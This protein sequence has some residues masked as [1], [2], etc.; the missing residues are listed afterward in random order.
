MRRAII[1]AASLALVV[2]VADA[3]NAKTSKNKGYGRAG[4]GFVQRDV[5]LAYQPGY[6]RPN[7]YR[8]NA[9]LKYGPQPDYPQS[10]PGGG[11]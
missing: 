3:A 2:G 1:A 5:G 11:Y 10:P 7:Y 9:D 8:P 6:Y 4:K